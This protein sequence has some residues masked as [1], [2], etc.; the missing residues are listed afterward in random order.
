MVGEFT[1]TL[2]KLMLEGLRVSAGVAALSCSEN[3]GS[4]LPALAVSVT[5]CAVKTAEMVAA[6]VALV[7]PAATVTDEG[8]ATAELLLAKLAVKP[9]LAAAAFK[10]TV[11]VSVAAPVMEELAQVSAESTGTP[12]PVRLTALEAPDE[13]LLV[14]V[15]VPVTAPAAVG[16][17]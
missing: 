1:D 5:V 2:P 3:V 8:T 11:Q 16:S 7:A 14:K 4:A 10:E 6:K 9:P 17:N 15:S 13:E 12:V